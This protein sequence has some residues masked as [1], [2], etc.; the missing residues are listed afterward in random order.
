MVVGVLN[1]VDADGLYIVWVRF[2]DAAGNGFDAVAVARR[3]EA[4]NRTL[5]LFTQLHATA[6]QQHQVQAF[7]ANTDRVAVS[8]FGVGDLEAIG[9]GGGLAA[10]R[11]SWG[12]HRAHQ[13]TN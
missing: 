9:Q 2:F 7:A 6:G 5:A 13:S 1:F 12:A 3:N 8:G 10:T 4:Q 11:A